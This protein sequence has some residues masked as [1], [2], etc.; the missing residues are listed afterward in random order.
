MHKIFSAFTAA[1]VLVALSQSAGAA[2]L[3][4]R[5][6]AAPFLAPTP[7]YNWTGIYFGING[8]GG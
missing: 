5:P 1:T 2:D 4:Q 6:T 8:G 3:P 7:V